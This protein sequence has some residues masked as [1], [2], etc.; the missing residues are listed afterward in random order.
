MRIETIAYRCVHGKE[1]RG[2][3]RWAFSANRSNPRHDADPNHYDAIHWAPYPMTL[4]AAKSWLR[5]TVGRHS[6]LVYY[7]LP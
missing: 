7:V 6:R 5:K 4:T 3:G 1:P 2:Q